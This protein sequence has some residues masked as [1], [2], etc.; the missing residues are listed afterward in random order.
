MEGQNKTPEKFV[1]V[2]SPYFNDPQTAV[3]ERCRIL[4]LPFTFRRFSP[5]MAVND[6][7]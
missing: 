6:C 4:D 3:T 1:L 7:T 2:N 5:D